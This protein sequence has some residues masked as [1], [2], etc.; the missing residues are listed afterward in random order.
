[1]RA[2]VVAVHVFT[3]REKQ[4][5]ME[6]FGLPEDMLHTLQWPLWGMDYSVKS[7]ELALWHRQLDTR[8]VDWDSEVHDPI[9]STKAGYVLASGYNSCDWKTLFEAARFGNWPLVV[10]CANEGDL[11]LVTALNKNGRAKV[12]T[13][14]N[15][16]DHNRLVIGATIYA[17]CLKENLKS[18]GQGRLA[19]AIAAAVPVVASNVLGLEGSLID[20]VTAIAV[21]PGNPAALARAIENLMHEPDRRAALA[22]AA[23]K[24]AVKF[25]KDYYFSELRKLLS[26]CLDNRR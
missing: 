10:A 1:M 14:V 15:A 2:S 23:K 8:P 12:L 20:G 25:S 16:A 26:I 21:E 18:N 9:G 19:E 3:N 22:A 4:I 17:L 7:A 13:K 5:F 24:H 6:R 11:P